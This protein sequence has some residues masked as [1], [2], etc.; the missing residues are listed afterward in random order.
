MGIVA[1]L[2]EETEKPAMSRLN[3]KYERFWKQIIKC[4]EINLFC[5]GFECYDKVQTYNYLDTKEL[6]YNVDSS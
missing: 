2:I 3:V 1:K 5:K 6:I 4:D